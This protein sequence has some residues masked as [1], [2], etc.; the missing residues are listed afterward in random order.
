MGHF[1]SWHYLPIINQLLSI[2]GST[3]ASLWPFLEKTGTLVTGISV[4][5]L[6]S[7]ET[8]GAAEALEDDFAPL[9]HP[10]KIHSY[11]FHPTGDHHLAGIDAAAYSFG[12]SAD[13]LPFSVGAWIQP[14]AIATNVIIAKY[15]SAGSKEEW[16]LWIDSNGKLSLELHDASE[17]ASEI[18][19][20]DTTL[21]IGQWGFVVATYDGGQA[22]PVVNLYL[23]GVLDNDG[24]TVEAG[25][26][27]AME[28]TTAPLTIGCSGVTATPV[29]E[30][31]GR[32]TLPFITGKV[33]TA[34]EIG[35][36]YELTKVL[37]GAE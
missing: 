13:D 5:D 15:D 26:Y 16:R 22:A 36:L 29:A 10:G 18:A 30:F 3:K 8:G 1:G 2:L 21:S 37:L 12:D 20:G 24:A 31:H 9:E 25:A 7:A 35:Q 17:S 27:A 11:H 4:G 19:T 28:D 32:I 34:A 23:N 14:N 33:L 6:T